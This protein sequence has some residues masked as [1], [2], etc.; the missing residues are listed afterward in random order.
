[1]RKFVQDSPETIVCDFDP[2]S[3]EWTCYSLAYVFPP[4]PWEVLEVSGE[5]LCSPDMECVCF[6]PEKGKTIWKSR[7]RSAGLDVIRERIGRGA[8]EQA[9]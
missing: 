7:S 9:V 4:V 1:L 6:R 8:V 2:S 5:K 3:R